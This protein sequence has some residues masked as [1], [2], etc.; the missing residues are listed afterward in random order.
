MIHAERPGDEASTVQ[1]I[2]R[3]FRKGGTKYSR[4]FCAG[5]Q[6]NRGCQISHEH[7]AALDMACGALNAVSRV[8]ANLCTNLCYH[9][10]A[11]GGVMAT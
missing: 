9:M 6:K 8:P 1:N 11:E 3:I 2:L 10:Q 4:I 7:R 5:V